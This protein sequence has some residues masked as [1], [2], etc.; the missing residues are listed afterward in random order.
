VD[1]ILFTRNDSC[2]KQNQG[3]AIIGERSWDRQR[4]PAHGTSAYGYQSATEQQG[5]LAAARS[6]NYALVIIVK[7]GTIAMSTPRKAD[8]SDLDRRELHLT[9]FACAAI[10]IMGVGSALLMYPVVFNHQ[11]SSPDRTLRVAFF[12]F[13]GLCLLLTAY[14]GDTQASLRRLRR[15]VEL[16]RK[17][18]LE[19][20]RQASEELLKNI[21]NLNSFQDRLPME[22]RR[23]MAT[24]QPLSILVVSLQF[25]ADVSSPAVRAP[26][27]GDAAKTISRKLR[28][29]DSLYVLAPASFCAVLPGVEFSAARGMAS[30]VAEG[31]ID[32]AGLSARFSYKIDVVN[33]PEHASSAHQLYEA[34]VGMIPM[35]TSKHQLAAEALT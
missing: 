24:Q 13:C 3:A 17:Q 1:Q 8:S 6:L 20:R 26:I 4:R 10:A 21:P 15:Q 23:T 25:S 30:R 32:A 34:V 2:K 18:S 11:S 16:D 5:R 7:D 12:G 19:A 29:Q 35:D 31:L 28:D 9:I 33:C 22:Y 27:L 14:V